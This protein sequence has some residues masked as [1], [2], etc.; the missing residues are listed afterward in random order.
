MLGEALLSNA[1]I[2]RQYRATREPAAYRRYE[3]YLLVNTT[4][5]KHFQ[6]AASNVSTEPMSIRTDNVL[7]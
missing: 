2:Q 6:D 7:R 5:P 4:D 1:N 3:E